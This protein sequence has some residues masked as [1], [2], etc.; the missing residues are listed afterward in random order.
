MS[1]GASKN[2]HLHVCTRCGN[3][4]RWPGI[5]KLDDEEITRIADYLAI[6]VDTFIE[7]YTELRPDR[8]GLTLGERPGDGACVM[9]EGQNRCRINAVKP[10]QCRDFPNGWN[11]P[12]FEKEC[13]AVKLRYTMQRLQRNATTCYG[14]STSL[15]RT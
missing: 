7:T 3:C 12:G 1:P 8:R 5:V 2:Q 11:F 10:E 9:L 15:P 4:C 6:T 14:T 13:P